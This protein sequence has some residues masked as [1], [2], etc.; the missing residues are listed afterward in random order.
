MTEISEFINQ[1]LLTITAA[2]MVLTCI[3]S[4]VAVLALFEVIKLKNRYNKL[5][6]GSGDSD[7]LEEQFKKFY[8]TSEQINEKYDKI[9]EAVMDL[10]KN[11]D[12]CVQKV[13]II[14]YNPFDEAGGNLCF[15]IALLD[16]KNN[17]IILNG[18]HSRSG[19]YTYAKPVE[20]GVSEYILSQEEIQALNMALEDSFVSDTRQEV[21]KEIQERYENE[22]LPG[23]SRKKSGILAR[24]KPKAS[25][26]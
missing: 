21:V 26:Q 25:V 13:G 6:G 18:I 12:K 10:S 11:M 19:C 1:N 3:V 22:I 8:E 2:L 15:A 17:G 7:T 14:R 23:R 16:S 5:A 24:K 9:S 4:V 20:L